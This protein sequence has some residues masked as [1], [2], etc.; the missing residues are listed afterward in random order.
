MARIA[1]ARCACTRPFAGPRKA[2]LPASKSLKCHWPS[3]PAV[4]LPR[5]GAGCQQPL[6]FLHSAILSMITGI[7]PRLF[8]IL[9]SRHPS[10]RMRASTILAISCLAIG[11]YPSFRPMTP[12]KGSDHGTPKLYK[13]ASGVVFRRGLF[14]A[15]LSRGGRSRASPYSENDS[16]AG[17]SHCKVSE[18]CGAAC[19]DRYIE[20]RLARSLIGRAHD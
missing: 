7:L 2:V 20:W 14:L 18:T 19:T 4:L 11:Y 13:L 1:V 9:I 6:Y 5:V 16:P 10:Q 15:H 8:I 12:A 3:F 17:R